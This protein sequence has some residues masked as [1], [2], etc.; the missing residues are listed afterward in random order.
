[1]KYGA[2]VKKR[3][4]SCVYLKFIYI[5]LQEYDMGS[6]LGNLS[7]NRGNESARP[8]PSGCEVYHNLS[9]HFILRGPHK[10]LQ[11]NFRHHSLKENSTNL[12]QENHKDCRLKTRSRAAISEP[13]RYTDKNML[14]FIKF[15]RIH[16]MLK[17]FHLVH[18]SCTPEQQEY[19]HCNL[20]ILIQTV[21]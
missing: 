11:S 2:N 16:F 7:K 1:M 8:T 6:F 21:Q 14:C 9:Q 19:K 10:K 20:D 17:S 12:L 15:C 5:H 18:L 13:T 4:A 3:K